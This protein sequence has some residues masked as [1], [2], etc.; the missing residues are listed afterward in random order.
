MALYY[1]LLDTD[2]LKS[3]RTARVICDGL[4]FAYLVLKDSSII[5][6]VSYFKVLIVF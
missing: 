4:R 6:G 5:T 3:S 2:K 1:L